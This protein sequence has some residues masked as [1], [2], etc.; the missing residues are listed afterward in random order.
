MSYT[1]N[2]S[3]PPRGALLPQR[4][5][6]EQVLS[7]W[8]QQGPQPLHTN[9]L[10][11][12]SHLACRPIWD[13]KLSL[14]PIPA[15]TA[16]AAFPATAWETGTVMLVMQRLQELAAF[17]G[18][19]QLRTASCVRCLNPSCNYLGTGAEM[20]TLLRRKVDMRWRW[21]SSLEAAIQEAFSQPPLQLSPF[22]KAHSTTRPSCNAAA[23]TKLVYVTELLFCRQEQQV[24]GPVQS[25]QP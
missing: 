13:C 6:S 9:C 3:Q 16:T 22:V 17:C 18:V 2:M 19:F 12:K 11:S 8:Q 15:L 20:S 23:I 21:L 24:K 14:H 7:L 1:G 25:L 4:S 5:S 10:L